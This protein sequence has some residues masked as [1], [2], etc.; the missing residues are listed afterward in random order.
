LSLHNG[1][2]G[3][4]GE[5]DEKI[6]VDAEVFPSHFGTGTEDYYGYS[7]GNAASFE[8]PFHAQPRGK[9]NNAVAYT[10]NTRTRGLDAI[11]FDKSLRLD[12][13]L[14][15]WASTKLTCAVATHWYA[16]QD[17]TCNV[18]SDVA[19]AAAKIDPEVSQ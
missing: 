5:G 18:F 10:T 17:S 19:A 4:W 7:Y 9:G 12:M 16:T 11:P 15:H 2:A 6:F 3:W 13:E 8:A 14:W 1:A